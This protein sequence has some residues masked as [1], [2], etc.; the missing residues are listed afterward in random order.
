MIRKAAAIELARDVAPKGADDLHIK[1]IASLI[2]ERVQHDELKQAEEAM[3][4]AEV[5][6]AA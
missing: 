5:N 6:H 3:K 1:L 4:R 2:I